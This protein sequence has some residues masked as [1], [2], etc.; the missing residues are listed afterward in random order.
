MIAAAPAQDTRAPAPEAVATIRDTGR[1]RLAER[2]RATV[3]LGLAAGAGALGGGWLASG[4]LAVLGAVAGAVLGFAVAR[5]G[6]RGAPG[7]PVLTYHS[8]SPDARWLP[9]AE[10]TSIRPAS[11]ERHLRLMRRLGL[12]VLDSEQVVRDRL[13]GKPL[14]RGAICLHFDDGYLDT[15]ACA[16]PILQ[17]HGVRATVFVSTD[18]I[19]PDQPLRP[20]THTAARPRLDGFMTW[21]ELRMLEASRE[22]RVEAHGTDHGRVA[23]SAEVVGTLSPGNLRQEAWMQWARMSGAKHDWYLRKPVVP[24]GTPIPTSA[25]SLAARAWDGARQETEAEYDARVRATFEACKAAFRRELGR[26]PVLFC[27]P[28]NVASARGR[29]LAAEAGFLATTGGRGRNADPARAGIIAR[30][31]AGQD[32][33]GFRCGLVDS[34]ALK[35][36]IRCF[37]GD[38]GWAPVLAAIGALRRLVLAARRLKRRLPAG[39]AAMIGQGEAL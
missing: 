30:V 21:R 15:W 13:A 4:G 20:T 26:E 7:L 36:H 2:R 18:F 33:G 5:R 28:Q 17:K 19:A 32:Y 1:S 8:V 6:L 31:H 3:I 24:L 12:R 9:W 11:L 37:Q 10:Q 23:T 39:T 25:P 16:W 22:F 35:A 14:P 38:M 29:A 27:W 34:I